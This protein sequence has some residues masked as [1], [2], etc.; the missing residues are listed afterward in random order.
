MHVHAGQVDL[1]GVQRALRHDLLDLDAG[2][3]GLG[4][5]GYTG[6]AGLNGLAYSGYAGLGGLGYAGLGY[7]GLGYAGLGYSGLG[8]RGLGY[9]R[10]GLGLNRFRPYGSMVPATTTVTAEEEAPE[11][12][13]PTPGA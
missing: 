11:E 13:D 10:F 2:L 8:Y 4:Y 5:S 7:R 3:G 12:V 6:L 9:N 1:V